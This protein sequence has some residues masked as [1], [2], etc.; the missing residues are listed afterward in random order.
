MITGKRFAMIVRVSQSLVTYVQERSS[1]EQSNLCTLRWGR[2]WRTVQ[3][4]CK[5]PQVSA[6]RR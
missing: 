6:T 4:Q 5:P 1:V 2:S 3:T